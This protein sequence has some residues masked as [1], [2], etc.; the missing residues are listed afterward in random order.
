MLGRS[1]SVQL[2]SAFIPLLLASACGQKTSLDE[3]KKCFEDR[4]NPLLERSARGDD[5]TTAKIDEEVMNNIARE[6]EFTDS[7]RADY[8]RDNQVIFLNVGAHKG[9]FEQSPSGSL[10][11]SWPMNPNPTSS[12][13]PDPS[14]TVTVTA[15]PSPMVTVTPTV[16]PSPTV[17]ASPNP[18][19]MPTITITPTASPSPS[20]IPTVTVTVT[21]SPSPTVTVTV[22]P[23]PSPTV[24]VT[25]TPSP[26]PSPT[27]SQTPSPSPTVTVTPSPTLSPTPSQTPSPSPTVTVTPSPT[28]SPTPSQTPSPS[29]TVTVTPSPTPTA[30]PVPGAVTDQ[31]LYDPSQVLAMTPDDGVCRVR[32]FAGPNAGSRKGY[33]VLSGRGFTHATGQS[34][35]A[36]AMSILRQMVANGTCMRGAAETCN[37]R[38]RTFTKSGAAMGFYAAIEGN[39]LNEKGFKNA[40][41]AT[42]LFQTFEKEGLCKLQN[43][44]PNCSIAQVAGAMSGY[45]VLSTLQG[46]M[47]D[48]P[49]SSL[50]VVDLYM[51]LLKDKLYC[52]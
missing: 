5:W 8:F 36:G 48:Q 21:P 49:Y 3:K 31:P 28:P 32:F 30:P 45:V 9:G 17:T 10:P 15:S 51:Q 38:Y 25:V 43:P 44:L 1:K 35:L 41:E 7:E 29:P 6:C 23:S 19:P 33:N 18:S 16:T 13:L 42:A 27:P 24:T 11:K 39:D 37:M 34:T 47:Q 40:G 46:W 52:Q 4:M 2:L 12:V 22:T 26:T 14:P 50:V 20:P